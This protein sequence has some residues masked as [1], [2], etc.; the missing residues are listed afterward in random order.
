LADILIVEDDFDV[1]DAVAALLASEG[2]R[3]R[4]ARNG[5]EGLRAVAD[6]VPDLI[7]LDV[8]MPILDGPG[9]V[10]ELDIRRAGQLRIPIVLI[11]AAMKLDR[12]ALW[13]GAPYSLK[14]PF[15]PARLLALVNDALRG[16]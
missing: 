5:A 4:L 1:A 13:L 8:E 11:S 16:G 10:E 12:I 9:M 14:K 3:P 2:Y 6:A 7:V 15:A